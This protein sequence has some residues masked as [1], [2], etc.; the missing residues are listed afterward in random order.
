MKP[1]IAI[2][3]EFLERQAGEVEGHSREEIPPEVRERLRAFAKGQAGEAERA[4]MVRLLNENPWWISALA[5]EVRQAEG[6]NEQK[7]SV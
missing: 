7:G 3:L 4:A 1:D 5:E 6:A 2:L